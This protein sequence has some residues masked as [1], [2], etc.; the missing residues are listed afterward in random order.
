MGLFVEIFSIF[1]AQ[2]INKS[3]HII[4]RNTMTTIIIQAIDPSQINHIIAYA[5][6]ENLKFE[7]SEFD[8]TYMS[9]DQLYAK[10]DRGIEEYQQ[11][12]SKK[13]DISEINSFLG[14]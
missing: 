4:K 1:A 11:G 14:L 2:N 12:K 6:K 5:E 3:D 13:L 10:I 8:D 7:V 9:K